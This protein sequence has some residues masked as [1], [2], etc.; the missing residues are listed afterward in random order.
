MKYK[1]ISRGLRLQILVPIATVLFSALLGLTQTTN[2]AQQNRRS[3][4]VHMQQIQVASPDGNIKFTLL[5]NAERLT[6]TVTMG[7]T[8]AIEP[9]P[10]VM[11]LNDY[12]LSS[13]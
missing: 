2:P 3:Q 12:D 4:R 9:S 7:G 10:I 1:E 13:G 11:K 8:T 5:P 6:Y